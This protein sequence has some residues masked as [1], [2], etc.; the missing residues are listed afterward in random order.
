[1]AAAYPHYVEGLG[2]LRRYDRP[3]NI[4]NA[5]AAFGRA[6]AADPKY[7]LAHA[8]AAQA[9]WRRFE[10]L[11]EPEAIEA[12]LESATR[13]LALDDRLPAAHITM[14]MIRAGKGQHE[15]AEQALQ[16]ALKI[17]RYDADAY[18]ELATVYEATKRVPK[19]E[20]TY[21]K[22]IELPQRGTGGA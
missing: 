17:D 13:A 4:A 3:Q 15:L 9:Q 14:G 19:A 12:A 18:R 6:V 16:Q 1:V 7:A 20:A 5:I 8:G 22:A 21:L 2:Y 11:R 10:A